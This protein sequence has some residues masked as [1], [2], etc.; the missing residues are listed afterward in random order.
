MATYNLLEL[1]RPVL[2]GT[3]RGFKILGGVI[4]N[5][6]SSTHAIIIETKCLYILYAEIT[7]GD[8]S[9]P[10]TSTIAASTL[11][12]GTKRITFTIPATGTNGGV[13]NV[14][15]L[16]SNELPNS[17]SLNTDSTVIASEL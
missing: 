8:N 14:S 1:L 13:A 7:Q 2:P 3:L 16:A 10:I 15:I 12:P 17:V 11:Y 5:T 4:T 9:T 6:D